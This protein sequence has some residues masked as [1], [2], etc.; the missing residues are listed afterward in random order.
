MAHHIMFYL[1]L[2]EDYISE[3]RSINGGGIQI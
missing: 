2:F 1:P 3:L